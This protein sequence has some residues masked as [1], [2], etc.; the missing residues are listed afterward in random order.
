MQTTSR[1]AGSGVL[2]GISATLAIA[3]LVLGA[4]A[5]LAAPGASGFARGLPRSA[6]PLPPVEG[7]VIVRFK[8][9]SSIV[10][11]HAPGAQ[12]KPETAPVVLAGR[13]AM[14][15]RRVGR[16]L[17]AGH[18]VGER[19]QVMRQRGAD[20]AELARHL[21][22][23]PEVEFAEPNQ[24]MRRL[25]AVTPTDP[26]YTSGPAV[27]LPLQTGGPTVGQWYLRKPDSTLRSSID[28][29]TA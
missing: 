10:R 2:A 13:A 5:T 1:A 26:L 27:S 24:R 28:A 25:Q 14:L 16:T 8:A 6:K 7:E 22:A 29:T 19:T 3:L 4:N 11:A 21:A 20:A 15:G 17:E 18:A 23:D 12:A 9:D